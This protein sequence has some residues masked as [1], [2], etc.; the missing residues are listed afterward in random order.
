MQHFEEDFEKS[1]RTDPSEDEN[2]T[3]EN[4]SNHVPTPENNSSN[5]VPTQENNSSNHVS[6]QENDSSNH[7]PTQENNI[8]NHVSTQENENSNHA[9][10][11]GEKPGNQNKETTQ[12]EK[13][14]NQGK[15]S[16]TSSPVPPVEITA[17]MNEIDEIFANGYGE[18]C[19]QDQVNTQ[20]EMSD[21]EQESMNS[22]LEN[23]EDSM[24]MDA[25]NKAP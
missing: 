22:D 12:V 24:D 19:D 16:R 2:Y 14:C 18:K 3:Q 13:S 25:I 23:F 4:N 10:T 7:V 21:S 8:S 1:Q 9:T 11:Q 15:E 17:L 20:K 5:H 6:T